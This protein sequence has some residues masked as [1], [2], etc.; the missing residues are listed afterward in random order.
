MTSFAPDT[1]RLASLMLGYLL[2]GAVFGTFFY[3]GLWRTLARP[4]PAW[5]IALSSLGRLA[6]LGLALMLLSHQGAL[7]LLL[8]MLGILGAR[9]VIV[10][11]FREAHS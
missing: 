9:S 4:R 3:V 2:L 5:L 11:Q 8:A 10:R 1:I 7:P 6:L